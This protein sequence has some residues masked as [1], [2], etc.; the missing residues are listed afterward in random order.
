MSQQEVECALHIEQIVR[1]ACHLNNVA[2]LLVSC[3]SA[4]GNEPHVKES[5]YMSLYRSASGCQKNRKEKKNQKFKSESGEEREINRS[6]SL[7]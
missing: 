5:D 4:D 3:Q 7:I 1:E 2:E 6:D